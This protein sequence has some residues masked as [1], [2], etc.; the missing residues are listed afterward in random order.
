MID[1]P[2]NQLAEVRAILDR[3]LP[4][5]CG[6]LVFGSRVK[7]QAK[8]YSDLDLALVGVGP[9]GLDCMGRLREAFAESS[10]PIRVDLLDWHAVP[11]TFQKLIGQ[12]HEVLIHSASASR[13]SAN[14]TNHV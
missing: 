1:L 12:G 3:H 6:V 4:E 10:L 9:L 8:P 7:G 5:G 11:E 14:Q 13:L 2:P